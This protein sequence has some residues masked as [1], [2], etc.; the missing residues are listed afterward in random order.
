MGSRSKRTNSRPPPVA[1]RIRKAV[2]VEMENQ[3][4][5]IKDTMLDLADRVHWIECFL[6]GER[7]GGNG[8]NQ[9]KQTKTTDKVA[10]ESVVQRQDGSSEDQEV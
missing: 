6:A 2:K 10:Q 3:L 7:D 1:D 4:K 8:D 5:P 9:Q